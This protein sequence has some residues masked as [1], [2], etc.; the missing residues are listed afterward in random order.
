MPTSC[1]DEVP[2]NVKRYMFISFDIGKNSYVPGR[3][4]WIQRNRTM[5]GTRRISAGLQTTSHISDAVD[6]VRHFNGLKR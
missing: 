6:V 3:Q 1:A 5:V 4:L 2:C